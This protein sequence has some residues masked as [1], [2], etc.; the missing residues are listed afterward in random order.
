MASLHKLLSEE[1]FQRQKWRKPQKKVK[2]KEVSAQ[3][4]SIALPIYI[5]HDRRSFDSSLQRAERALSQ[6]G[7]SVVSSRKGGS[8]SERSN[9]TRSVSEGVVP[10]RDEPAIDD[11]AVKAMISILNG[12][13]GQYLRDKSFRES[14]REK[15][16]SCF[17]RRKKHSD[18][19][20]FAHMELGI[21]S[22]ERLVEKYD[23]KKGMDLDSLQKS[24][25]LFDFVASM[26]PKNSKSNA[27]T[28][29]TPNSYLSAC[30]QL[31]LSIVYK[32]ARN[33]RISARHLLQVFCD[34]PFL[35]RTHLLPELWEHFFLPHLL[36]L[37]IWYTKELDI[38]S[39]S[40]YDEEGKKIKSL[41]ELYN[42][43]MD[44]GTMKFAMYYKEWLKVGAQAPSVPSIPLPSKLSNTRSRRRSADSTNAHFSLV[45][46][47]LYQEVFGPIPKGRSL[48]LENRNRASKKSD[49]DSEEENISGLEDDLKSSSQSCRIQKVER[50]SSD[51]QKTDYF[52]I[53]ACRTEPVEC[54]IKGS[55]LPKNCEKFKNDGTEDHIESDD[56]TRAIATICSSESLSDCEMAIRSI[57]KCWLN[58]HGDPRIE[59]LLSEPSVIQ[60]IME[61]LFVSN[62]DEILE[63]A[64]SI[65][66][67]LATKSETSRQSIL[68]SD[69]QLDVSVRLLRS[70]SL[71]LK[72]A[73]MLYLAKP[74]AKQM[75]SSDWIPLVLRV[76]EF[77]DH[78]QTLLTV[79]CRPHVAAYYF[80]D[81]LLTG[82]NE[83]KNLENAR[84]IIS[85]GGLG[86][87]VRR[88]EEGNTFEKSEAASVLYYCIQA[89]GSCRHY[90]AKN[91]RKDTIL[92]L[93]VL[94]KHTNSQGRALELLTES[95]CLSRR[96]QRMESLSTLAK[97]WGCLNTM[98]ILLL[99]LQKARAQERPIIAVILLQLDLMGNPSECSIYGE[100]A[101]DAIVK[102]LDC[103]VFDEKVQEQAARAL[104]ILG[105]HFSYTG[106]PEVE[107][108][109][110]RKA[111]FNEN[112]EASCYGTD[113]DIYGCL[114]L[115]EEDKMR[116]NLQRKA[117]LVLL[118][119][120]NTRLVSSLSNAIGNGISCLSRASLVT[121]CWMISGLRLFGDEDLQYAACSILVPQ[122][123]QSLNYDRALEERILASLSLLTLTKSTD[124]FA[125][126]PLDKGVLGCLGRLCDVTWTAEELINLHE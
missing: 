102:A 4:E 10:R 34:S 42:D 97:G 123:R 113:S 27:S 57:S 120:G 47:S 101:I 121:V 122:L 85:L 90:L 38:L 93:L 51:S 80:L 74:K 9:H 30:A 21:Q 43:Q 53:L 66:A 41:N 35:A 16:Y 125:T 62:E 95:L 81:Q 18:N 78:V 89:D 36:H 45:N 115:G 107:K 110:L 19:D 119:R 39:C 69:P 63:L 126:F 73:V 59:Y 26:N 37:K 104:L 23:P 124:Y 1:G 40:D 71:F 6:K 83:D 68:N 109:L 108:W 103:K 79:K 77:G 87:L 117:A 111:G 114:N 15:C 65:L 61:V 20:I 96:K 48:D 14:I 91:L 94:G 7:S 32:T 60:G 11:V 22:I 3:E 70:G 76:L 82:F 67:E 5:C 29:G 84:Q 99:H 25:K 86:L 98:H 75:I 8:S 105:G 12:Y 28:R 55:N 88:M 46:K 116:E 58:S 112:N 118:S 54:F 64:I 17:A 100:E 72:A 24:I 44:N 13:V 52:R 31:Y 2:F 33:D 49:W 92:S 106:E 50:R 56:V